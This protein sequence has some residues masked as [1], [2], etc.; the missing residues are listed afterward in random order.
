[1]HRMTASLCSS[2]LTE[3]LS[4]I[5]SSTGRGGSAADIAAFAYCTANS[6]DPY[7]L[8][9]R[10]V[11]PQQQHFPYALREI[12]NGKKQGHWSWFC[13]PTPPF[14]LNGV[15]CGSLMN[16]KYALRDFP[17]NDTVGYDA[18]RS[19]LKQLPVT[20][21]DGGVC[22]RDNYL[23][24]IEAAAQQ[25]E[26][27]NNEENLWGLLDAPKARSGIKLFEKVSRG[28]AAKE[29]RDAEVNE[30]CRRYAKL[31]GETLEP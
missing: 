24:L 19:Y 2:H 20:D 30:I 7:N 18:A 12:R 11:I 25:L 15:E 16:R 17:P 8:Q 6:A 31:V 26:S 27:G 10:F 22:L 5:S 29:M 28:S 9:Q 1:M 3:F 23:L 21:G 4:R 14:M 13:L